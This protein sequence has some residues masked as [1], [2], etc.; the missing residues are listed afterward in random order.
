MSTGT[1]KALKWFAVIYVFVFGILLWS[2][3]FVSWANRMEPWIGGVN[4]FFG[5]LL[6]VGLVL[7]LGVIVF[8]FTILD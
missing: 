8:C 7:N 5:Y 4:F 2:P 1:K 6:L 3:P